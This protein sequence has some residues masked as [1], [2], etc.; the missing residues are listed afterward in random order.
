MN[1]T[2]N[3]F[4]Q[5]L[6][7]SDNYIGSIYKSA[8]LLCFDLYS[9]C[10]SNVRIKHTNNDEFIVT[11]EVTGNELIYGVFDS[12]DE[13]IEMGEEVIRETD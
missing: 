8:S 5:S 13:A 11:E 6:D 3:L 12:M 9:F 1:T 2:T 7:L 4:S 10:E